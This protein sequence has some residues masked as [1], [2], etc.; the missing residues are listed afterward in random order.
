MP[1]DPDASDK[2]MGNVGPADITKLRNIGRQYSVKYKLDLVVYDVISVL[3]R[4]CITTQ[5]GHKIH[6]DNFFTS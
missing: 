2:C 4:A 3:E 6:F 1:T 5:C